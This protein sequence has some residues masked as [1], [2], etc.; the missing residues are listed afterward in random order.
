MRQKDDFRLVRRRNSD[1][2]RYI[3]KELI[4]LWFRSD[5]CFVVI[6]LLVVLS[7]VWLYLP[8]SD[9]LSQHCFI[10]RINQII[11]VLLLVIASASTLASISYPNKICS[12]TSPKMGF[13]Y[14]NLAF[15]RRNFDQQPLKV[16]HKVSLS[17]NFQRQSCSAINWLS[18]GINNLAVDDPV[19]VKFGPKG[20]DS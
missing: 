2:M 5:S 11:P 8:V 19:P 13:R 3:A 9:C 18:N 17:K 14:P 20:T 7:A 10:D 12:L 16:C 4:W 15:F 6:Y 1:S